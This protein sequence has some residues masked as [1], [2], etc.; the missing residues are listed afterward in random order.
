VSRVDAHQ[1]FWR[2]ARVD[3]GWLTPAAGPLYRDFEPLDLLAE[4][5]ACGVNATI[6]GQAAPMDEESR[7]LLDLARRYP[8]IAG[9]RGLG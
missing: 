7:F 5:A 3:Y 2:L 6:L 9:D 4:L 1:H 8:V